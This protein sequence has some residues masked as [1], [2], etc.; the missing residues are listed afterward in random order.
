MKSSTSH[1]ASSNTERDLRMQPKL[2]IAA[3]LFSEA[4]RRFNVELKQQLSG[5]FRVFLPQDDGGLLTELLKTGLNS[6]EAR[7]AVFEADIGALRSCDVLL[8]VLDG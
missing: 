1:L 8:I 3:P 4:E 6:S 2:Y 7:K 5:T